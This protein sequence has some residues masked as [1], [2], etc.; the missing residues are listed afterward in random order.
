[1][2]DARDAAQLLL[3]APTTCLS[4]VFPNTPSLGIHGK[5]IVDKGY[6]SAY[7]PVVNI[8]TRIAPLRGRIAELGVRKSDVAKQLGLDPTAFSAILNG[9]RTAPADFE[10]RVTAALD[11]LE[12]A[13]LAA[14][15]ARQ[16]V[17][18]EA[19]GAA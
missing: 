15:T 14:D 9:R 19:G 13:E 11:R 1:M 5:I 8:R 18:R 7:I 2:R 16:K 3:R 4:E 12:K 17:L 10:R 6:T